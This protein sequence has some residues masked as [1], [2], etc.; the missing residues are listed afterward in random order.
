MADHILDEHS[1][2]PGSF[3]VVIEDFVGSGPRSKD[4]TDTIKL[5]GFLEGLCKWKDIPYTVQHPQKRMH[6]LDRAKSTDSFSTLGYHAIDALAHVLA[7][8]GD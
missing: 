4:I 1:K 3:H 2:H 5:L 6:M 8:V 7:H